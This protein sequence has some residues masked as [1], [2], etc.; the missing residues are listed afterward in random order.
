MYP[1][2][3]RFSLFDLLLQESVSKIV[4]SLRESAPPLNFLYTWPQ[5]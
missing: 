5:S 4:E 1:E 3:K 2:R